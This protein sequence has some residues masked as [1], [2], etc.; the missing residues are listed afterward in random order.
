VRN[1]IALVGLGVG[2]DITERGMELLR[3]CDIAFCEIHTMPV[4]LEYVERLEQESG[5]KI[6]IVGREEVEGEFPF[7][8]GEARDKNVCLLCGGDPL[9]ATTHISLLMDAKKAGIE[10]EVVHNSSIFSAAAGKSGLQPYKFGK[11]V[12]VSFWRKNYEPTSPLLLIGKNLEAGMHT[13]V[14]MDLDAELG[15]MDAK[16]GLELLGKMEKK[17][18]KKV[19]PEKLVVL[20]RVGYPDEK[21]SYGTVPGLM[22]AELGDAPFCI[23][24]PGELH[25]MEL[26]Y[27]GSIEI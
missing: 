9:A 23:V 7:V 1:V 24:V 18:G 20:S 5:K 27:L 15:L 13:L 10:T 17:E 19:L 26:E 21:I 14:L 6:E 22:D 25:E 8:L 4:P 2:Y 3:D 16:L 12:T 11:T